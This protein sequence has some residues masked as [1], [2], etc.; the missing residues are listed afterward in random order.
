MGN[1]LRHRYERVELPVIW[2]TVQAD[3]PPLKAAVLGALNSPVRDPEGPSRQDDLPEAFVNR[4]RSH[5]RVGRYPAQA[6]IRLLLDDHS[7]HISKETQAY[8]SLHPRRFEFVFRRTMLERLH[9]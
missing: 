6:L 3:L 7:A 4:P 8:L 5:R 9:P 2:K 1:W